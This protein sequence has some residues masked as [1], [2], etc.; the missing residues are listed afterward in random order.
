MNWCCSDA[1][2][3]GWCVIK[4][5]PLA[6]IAL[7]LGTVTHIHGYALLTFWCRESEIIRHPMRLVEVDV[8]KELESRLQLPHGFFVSLPLAASQTDSR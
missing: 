2:G 3:L 8:I 7:R 6:T 5:E 1:P 4:V